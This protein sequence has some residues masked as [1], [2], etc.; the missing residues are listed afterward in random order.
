M[1]SFSKPFIAA[2]S[3]AVTVLFACEKPQN[4]ETFPLDDVPSVQTKLAELTSATGGTSGGSVISD[5]GYTVTKRGICWSTQMPTINNL[6]T[7]DGAGTG[8]FNSA[9]G[10]LKADE[11]YYIRAYATSE[12]GTGYGLPDSVYTNTGVLPYLRTAQAANIKHDSATVV[13][14]IG[15][16]GSEEADVY[17]ICYSMSPNPDTSDMKILTS[18]RNFKFPAILPELRSETEY[19]AR[20]LCYKGTELKYGNEISFTTKGFGC[21]PVKD[22]VKFDGV[23]VLLD[24]VSSSIG[25]GGTYFNMYGYTRYE[26]PGTPSYFSCYF[27]I[28]NNRFSG[29]SF[30]LEPWVQGQIAPDGVV[31]AVFEFA[32]KEY[33]AKPGTRVDIDRWDEYFYVLNMCDVEFTGVDTS[34]SFTIDFRMEYPL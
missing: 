17:G 19:F 16:V 27:T 2:L 7:V 25:G 14:L 8:S 11:V 10:A 12:K 13:G 4:S 29:G 23:N 34:H 5:G 30:S 18:V 21:S 26:T 22:R 3:V 28:N 24:S 6:R 20:S 33:V 15:Y 32:G 1:K 31:Y 9:F